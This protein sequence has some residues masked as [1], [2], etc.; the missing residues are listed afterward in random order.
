LTRGLGAG[1]AQALVLAGA[2]A[3]SGCFGSADEQPA[4]E[5]AH[6]SGPDLPA[7]QLERELG[8]GFRR[9]LYRLAVMSQHS[10]DATDLGQDLPTGLLDRV[11]CGG[12]GSRWTCTVRWKT[13]GGRPR[14]T[15][16]AV[17]Q[18]GGGCFS[19]GAEPPLP[20]RYDST[21]RSYAENP[22]NVV[23]STRRGC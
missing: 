18:L 21:I 14:T 3:L 11:R 2:L 12:T 4:K 19:A 16:Y 10:D 17:R 7:R 6:V 1:G 15:R 9:S 23:V 13:T 5:T 20:E 8:N 22:L